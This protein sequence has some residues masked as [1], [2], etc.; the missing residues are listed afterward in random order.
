MRWTDIELTG[1]DGHGEARRLLDAARRRR[2]ALDAAQGE[3]GLDSPAVTAAMAEVG[4]LLFRAATAADPTVFDPG[5]NGGAVEPRVG[6]PEADHAVGYHLILPPRRLELP[7]AWLHSGFDF[8]LE[9]HPVAVSPRPSIPPTGRGTPP[10]ARRWREAALAQEVRGDGLPRLV[11]RLRPAECGEAE[12][13]FVPGHCEPQVRRLIYREA[14][15]IRRALAAGALGRPLAVLS[16]LEE[17]VTPGLLRRRGPVYQGLHFAGP[18]SLPL[19][20]GGQPESFWLRELTSLA[21]D[22]PPETAAAGGRDLEVVGIDPVTALLDAVEEGA[23]AREL[24]PAG[25]PGL[26]E[27]G[28]GGAAD[29]GRHRGRGGPRGGALAGDP[30]LLEDGPVRPE[31]LGGAVPP[32]VFSNSYC[33][34]PAMGPRFLASGVSTFIGPLLPLYSRPARKLAGLFYSYLSDGHA[35]ASALRL[36]ALACRERFGAEHPA[37]LS[38]GLLGHGC[39]ALQYL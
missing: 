5:R 39:L 23:R 38:Y 12:V 29:S 16:V 27:A 4:G 6:Q 20:T 28:A 17:A 31:E 8:L 10:W 34:L 35:A 3:Q 24:S 26:G 9:R 11:R 30:W 25:V 21:A 14:D 18:T 36:A 32:L 13:L 19:S 7:W 15:A 2:A 33:G 1:I 22:E 37:W